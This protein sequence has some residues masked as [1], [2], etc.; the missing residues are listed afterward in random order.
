MRKFISWYKTGYH[1]NMKQYTIWD[2]IKKEIA[3]YN[4]LKPTD[5]VDY[6]KFYLYSIITHS[7]AIEGSTLTEFD[8]QL[9]FDEGIT[10]Q[11]KPLIHHLMNEDL[12][13]AYLFALR[14]AD[15]QTSITAGF[16]TDLNARIMKSTGGVVNVQ[17]DVFD[18]SKGEYRLCG[19]TAG[20]GGASYMSYLKIPEKVSELCGELHKRLDKN[21][22]IS[23]VYNIS[24]DAHLNLVTIHPWVDGN[25][26][27]ARLLMNYIQFLHK[28]IPTKIHKEDKG[29]YIAALMEAREKEDSGPFR[30]F[31][32]KEFLKTLK[33]EITNY[34]RGQSK[35]MTFMF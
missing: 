6:N 19:V 22:E 33:E 32:A 27:T 15:E 13:N 28:L 9:L 12:K 7:T 3:L 29:L 5:S 24:F 34:K 20:Y 16:L 14:K 21:C 18:S 1:Q 31:M 10:A 30:E 35:K 26:R 23:D 2:S 4:S 17:G 25:G 11:G 8:T